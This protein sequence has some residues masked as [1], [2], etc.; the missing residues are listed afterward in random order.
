MARPKS[1]ASL[2]VE[3]LLKMRA[4]IADTLARKAKELQS[5]LSLL[6]SHEAKST[7]RRNGKAHPAKGKKVA[8]KYRDP[9]TKATWAGRGAQPRWLREAKGRRYLG[10]V[11][12][13]EA[14]T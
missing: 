4:D 9:E 14:R 6:G 7:K 5:Q 11:C 10:V 2:S 12:R 8:P 13:W 1:F 3:T